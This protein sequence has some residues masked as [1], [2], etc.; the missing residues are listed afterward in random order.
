M[1]LRLPT[2]N[3]TH[4][5]GSLEQESEMLPTDPPP[6]IA[7]A[8]AWLLIVIFLAALAAAIF[9]RL[10]ETVRCRFVLVPRGGADPIQSP[11]AAVVAEVRVSE[12][13]EIPEDTELFILRSDEIG[14]L[15]TELQTI[16]EDLRAKKEA[17]IKL[18][19]AF[20]AQLEIKEG[21]IAQV[22]REVQFR[23]QH[24]TTSRDLVN[25]LAKLQSTGGISQVELIK[26]QLELAESEKDLNVSMK[27]LDQTLLEKKR[28]ETDRARQRND[29]ATEAKKLELRIDAL[30]TRLGNAAGERLTIRA[31][32]HAVVISLAQRNAGTVV[33][34]G[35]ELC[36]L[37]RIDAI[38]IARLSLS[39]RGLPRLAIE[40]RVRLF[41]D[42]F[43]YQ[44]YGTAMGTLEWISP[45]AVS[46][47]DGQTFVARAALAQTWIRAGGQQRQLR[48]GMKGEARILVGSRRLIEYAFEPVRQLRENLRP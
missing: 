46:S 2:Q 5:R 25:R 32:Y 21:E 8:I 16:S 40:Q 19:A 37:A 41:F 36:Q 24:A 6:R 45:A 15:N 20:S 17:A 48:P 44:R 29:E 10:P 3:T 4:P 27:L 26:H 34:A 9:V 43:P 22:R 30:K 35:Q 42:A 39:E 13:A 1:E 11:Y 14:K 33:N 23:E 28:M 7:R 12:G 18:E 38:P 47:A 31:P